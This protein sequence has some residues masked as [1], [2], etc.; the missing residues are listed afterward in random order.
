VMAPSLGICR[1]VDKLSGSSHVRFGQAPT[2]VHESLTV[3]TA[4]RPKSS[5]TPCGCISVS[6]SVPAAL[7]CGWPSVAS[8]SAYEA[9]RWGLPEGW[10]T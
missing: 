8:V 1:G 9:I 4:S 6:A 2:E 7:K 5:L 10:S 3:T